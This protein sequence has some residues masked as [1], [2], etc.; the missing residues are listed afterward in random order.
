MERI[1]ILSDYTPTEKPN[2]LTLIYDDQ[3]DVH[4]SLYEGS[5]D[6][7]FGTGEKG[8]RIAASGTRHSGRV[9]KAF[10]DLIKAYK[11]ELDDED[12]HRALKEQ[13]GLE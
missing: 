1:K 4:I 10:Y 7:E 8:V 12:C 5:K 2:V 6:K 9:R 13:N 11:E 3:G